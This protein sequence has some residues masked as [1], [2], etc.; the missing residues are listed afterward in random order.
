[1]KLAADM[2]VIVD[3]LADSEPQTIAEISFDSG[4]SEDRIGVAMAYLQKK[5]VVVRAPG[6]TPAAYRLA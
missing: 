2:Q 4:L 6:A 3:A 1:M 5:Q